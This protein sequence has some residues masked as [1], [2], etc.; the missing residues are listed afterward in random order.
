MN[1]FLIYV[2]FI[3]LKRM[4]VPQSIIGVIIW[5]ETALRLFVCRE[6]DLQAVVC[7]PNDHKTF[8]QVALHLV[9]FALSDLDQPLYTKSKE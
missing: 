9:T 5:S 8:S 2:L 1:I 6:F 4:A 7:R 3:V